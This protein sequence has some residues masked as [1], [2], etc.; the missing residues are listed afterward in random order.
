MTLPIKSHQSLRALR[1]VL[2]L[3]L[4]LATFGCAAPGPPQPPSLELPLPPTDLKAVRKGDRVLLSWTLP[5]ETTD[6][7]GIRFAGPTRICRSQREKMTECDVPVQEVPA[8]Q[9]DT[10]KQKTAANIPVRTT[11]QFK[12]LLP[13][14][15]MAD[16]KAFITYAIESLNTGKHGAGI[17]N[18]A[19]VPAARTEPP[20]ADFK[21]ELTAGGVVL[22]WKGP[23]LS[24]VAGP[25]VPRSIY[26]AY[27]TQE[28]ATERTLVGEVLMGR[29]TEMR[30]VDPAFTWEKTYEYRIEVVTHVDAQ[31]PDLCA[32][33]PSASE[34]AKPIRDAIDVEGEY[35]TPVKIVAHDV[36]PP[37]VPTALQAVFS[38]EGQIAFIDL[39]WTANAESDLAGYNVY[40]HEQGAQAEKVNS[41]LV[42]APSF[43]DMNVAA[44]KTYLYSI[45]SLDVR[46]NESARSEETS[47]QVP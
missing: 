47:E 24:L 2:A 1:G 46:G 38:G 29:E 32:L 39:T 36:F 34:C 18:T 33:N 37:T 22:T 21:G 42:K 45:T 43:R 17:S 11:A 10:Q 40:R 31:F 19:K 13:A 6:G 41:E 44:G 5:T 9:L 26:R 12:D 23:L 16:P 14:E 35:S 28:D 20:P 30:L 7:D 8:A 3:G 27:R 25:G 4:F 15:W